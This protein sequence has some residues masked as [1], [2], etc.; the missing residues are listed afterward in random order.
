MQCFY[1]FDVYG[2]H[3]AL[4][5]ALTQSALDRDG[6]GVGVTHAH[7]AVDSNVYL[8]GY[9]RPD[10]AC[11]EIVG[12]ADS[13]I[14]GND[15]EN[16]LL[17]LGRER[18]LDQLVKTLAEKVDCNLQDHRSHDNRCNRVGDDPLAA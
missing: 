4:A 10:A 2:D 3:R 16:L 14:L 13:G 17:D 18:S 1:R 5:K 15:A 12:L 8:D 6:Q 9:G 7:I 11:A